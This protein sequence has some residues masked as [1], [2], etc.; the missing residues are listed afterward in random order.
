VAA[1]AMAAAASALVSPRRRRGRGVRAAVTVAVSEQVQDELVPDSLRKHAATQA[2]VES[3][4]DVVKDLI[5]SKDEQERST[6]ETLLSEMTAL[7]NQ[8]SVLQT[9]YDEATDGLEMAQVEAEYHKD[10]RMEELETRAQEAEAAAAKLLK[11]H[12]M[13][14]GEVKTLTNKVVAMDAE[15]GKLHEHALAMERTIK[16]LEGQ[17]CAARDELQG[18]LNS[19][20]E[21]RATFLQQR[22]LVAAE[23]ARL[24]DQ[25]VT[26]AG[27]K[28]MLEKSLSAIEG[29]KNKLERNCVSLSEQLTAAQS[30]LSDVQELASAREQERARLV[31]EVE[32][33][34]AEKTRLKSKMAEVEQAR[35][36]SQT[37]MRSEVAELTRKVVATSEE[38]SQLREQ[39]DRLNGFEEAVSQLE[40]L[41]RLSVDDHSATFAQW[42]KLRRL[43]KYLPVFEQRGHSCLA[44]LRD[45][46]PDQISDLIAA[47]GMP[48]GHAQMLRR[49]LAQLGEEQGLRCAA[50]HQIEEALAV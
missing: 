31:S 3:L 48:V 30:S 21:E 49:G 12:S 33:M 36:R 15:R 25:V 24:T 28:A 42:L 39:V 9:A 6:N 26:S 41:S 13:F 27:D 16:T 40:A 37:V 10:S 34:E 5:D 2:S 23:V 44:S 7:K 35:L 11:Q 38:N 47:C 45:A 22:S 1:A 19:M 20:E 32:A 50:E 17:V 4:V 18:A 8:I 14:Q 46:R 43:D 29:E